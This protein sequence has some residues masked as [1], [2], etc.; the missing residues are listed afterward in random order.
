LIDLAG[1]TSPV[2]LTEVGSSTNVLGC[3]GRDLLCFWN[4]TNQILVRALRG[5]ELIP[6]GAITVDSGVRPTDVAY[7]ATR[8]LL[9]WAEGTN[10]ASVYLASL[11]APSRRIELKSDLPGIAPRSFSED[12]IHLIVGPARGNS[13]RAWNVETG[14]I[15]ASMN[16]R[17]RNATFAAG[18]RV[19]VV[20]SSKGT[21]H[22]IEFYDLAH[23]DRERQRVPGKHFTM[24]LAVSPDG[25]LVALSTEG[26]QVRLFDA[27]RG[28][29][30]EDLHGHL[31]AA[32]GV[33]FSPDGRRLVSGSVGGREAV[34][35]WDVGT[36]QELLTLSGAGSILTAAGWSADG[37]LI[38]AGAPWQAWRAPSWEEIATAEAKEKNQK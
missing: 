38:L 33:A 12:G 17:V 32:F 15:V 30:I 21:D 7:N 37:N 35:I 31:I 24:G 2:S 23:P 28:E 18:G 34:K 22:E 14:E 6:C 16:D 11:A 26:A 19:L 5:T 1:G 9:A 13:L 10:S 3:F 27:T 36:R 8:Q 29:W 25:R 20:A 4:A